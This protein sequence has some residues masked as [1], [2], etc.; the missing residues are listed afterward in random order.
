LEGKIYLFGTA[1]ETVDR[2]AGVDRE[3]D[4]VGGHPLQLVKK[5]HMGSCN[6]TGSACNPGIVPGSRNTM[7]LGRWGNL[8]LS[9]F[10]YQE[11]GYPA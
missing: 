4:F 2:A 8:A 7:A 6:S 10:L 5:D 9:I 1:S 11:L 3:P